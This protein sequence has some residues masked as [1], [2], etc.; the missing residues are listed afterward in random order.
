MKQILFLFLA[1]AISCKTSSDSE[2]NFDKVD[3]DKIYKIQLSPL[4]GSS[5]RYEIQNETKIEFEVERKSVENISR[6]F[7]VI[8]Y[9]ISNDSSANYLYK[10]SFDSIHLFSDKDGV[11][12]EFDAAN[13]SITIDPVEKMLGILKESTMEVVIDP[14]GAV[15]SVNGYDEIGD[16]IL[17][18]FPAT[19]A[20]TKAAIINQ[21][22][23]TLGES[24]VKK[25]LDQL[26]KIF[27]DSAV[28]LNDNW[29][30]TTKEKGE[31]NLDIFNDFTLKSI[32]TDL[33]LVQSEGKIKTSN[34]AVGMFG[35]SN[36][37]AN[38]NGKQEGEFEMETK[39]GM[40]HS[41]KIKADISGNIQAMGR[42]IP[43]SI[44]HRLKM[45]G[46]KIN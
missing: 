18:A 42:D 13:A 10:V 35:F 27:P 34:S 44:T 45:K 26:F 28:H 5:Y 39:T 4:A 36:A 30:L 19:D 9:R 11:E 16:K 31:F 32:N 37:V 8:Y 40:L 43:V 6:S 24:L 41:C 20:A 17:K 23:Q 14:K 1:I 22:S 33:A 46:K 38:L 25:N 3:P 12:S 29:N 2:G 15:I 21:W 7:V